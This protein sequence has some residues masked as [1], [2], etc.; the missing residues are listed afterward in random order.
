MNPIILIIRILNAA[1]N[2]SKL[3]NGELPKDFNK[4]PKDYDFEKKNCPNPPKNQ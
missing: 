3:G 2:P 4:C 1:L